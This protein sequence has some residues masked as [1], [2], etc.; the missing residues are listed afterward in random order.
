MASKESTT[1]QQTLCAVYARVSLDRQAESVEHQVSLLREFVKHRKLG[2]IPDEFIYQDTGVSATKHSIWSRPAMK[3][4]LNDA[5]EGKFQV[6]LFKGIS[7]FARNTQEALDVLDRLKSKGLRVISYEESYDSNKDNSNFLFTI[8]SAVAEYEAEKTA[9]RVRLGNKEKA[10]Q[11]L[12]TGMPPYGYDLKDRRLVVNDEEAEVVKKIFDMYVYQK[13]GTFKVAEY[14]N[15]HK[16]LKKN[17]RLWSRKTVGDVLK[18][19][20]YLGRVVY[21]KTNQKRVRDY[22]SEDTG[23]KKWVRKQND[24][25]DWVVVDNAH[26]ALVDEDTFKEA[27][28][29]LHSR[30][31]RDTAPNVYHPLTGI[32][33]CGRCGEGMVCQKRST[34]YGDYRY[35]ICKTYHKYGRTFCEQAN[36]NADDLEEYIIER[37]STKLRQFISEQDAQ[38]GLELSEVDRKRIEKKL[39]EIDAKIE[40]L[41]RDNADLYFERKNMNEEQ[42]RYLS[43]RIK[44][45]MDKLIEK[46][47][48]I[49]R[50]LLVSEQQED[51]RQ[52][53]NKHIEEFLSLN[54]EDIAHVRKLLHYFIEK[55]VLTDKHVDIYYRFSF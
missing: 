38:E 4:L 40:K 53:L 14:L 18:N 12:W 33:F 1:I 16:L 9:I 31:K 50:E 54:K 25:Q 49:E 27:Q 55:I 11:G 30:K 2:E 45:E 47:Q 42:Y 22:E 51:K 8:H 20:V 32:L 34:N 19:E 35:Y 13:M 15:E 6:V 17:G 48:S 7:R 41:N 36:T 3:Q 43:K 24:P 39:K 21:N 23:K 46:K 5:D 26:P 10:K 37:L 52:E 44:D 28:K 29:I